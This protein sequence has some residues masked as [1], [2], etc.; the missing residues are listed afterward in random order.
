LTGQSYITLVLDAS[1]P[2]PLYH[3]LAE[4]LRDGIARGQ[5][6]PGSKLPSEPELARRYAIG[7]P[8]VRQATEV[9]VRKGLCERRRGSGT[10]VLE[11][12]KAVSLFSLAGTASS[13]QNGGL[14]LTTRLLSGP[15]LC[16]P[17]SI[18]EPGG[19]PPDFGP[20]MLG[21]FDGSAIH[22]TRLGSLCTGPG[23]GAA[24][25]FHDVPWA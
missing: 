5:W 10:Y 17:R 13:F 2:L 23:G 21:L 3:Q 18:L 16:E 14:E 22:L 1:S 25:V 20:S 8:T 12:N 11:P 19:P 6:P 7:R 15:E 9:L 24:A 4:L